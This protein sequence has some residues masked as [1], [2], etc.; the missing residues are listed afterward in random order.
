MDCFSRSL[1]LELEDCG[2]KCSPIDEQ[3]QSW[4]RMKLE[5]PATYRIRVKGRLD[6]SWFDR[7]GGMVITKYSGQDE[8]Q[9]TVLVGHLIDQ[10]ALSDVLKAFYDLHLP[11]LSV[12]S[13]DKKRLDS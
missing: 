9:V 8:A 6:V 3:T 10:A 13:L 1:V 2:K 7:L 11:L 12:E 4:K 5:T